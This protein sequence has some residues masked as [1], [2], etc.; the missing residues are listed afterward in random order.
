MDDVRIGRVLRL[1]RRRLRLRLVDLADRARTSQSTISW[2]EAS[3]EIEAR[4]GSMRDTS[5]TRHDGGHSAPATR[6]N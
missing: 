3:N 1:L 4:P 2:I 6:R 5:A